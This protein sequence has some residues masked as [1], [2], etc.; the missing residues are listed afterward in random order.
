MEDI[1]PM[2]W[3]T[4]A[5]NAPE[6]LFSRLLRRQNVHEPRGTVHLLIRPWLIMGHRYEPIIPVNFESGPLCHVWDPCL[7]RKLLVQNIL[8][9]PS[10]HISTCLN[11]LA[12]W[13]Q[14]F[15]PSRPGSAFPCT[16]ISHQSNYWSPLTCKYRKNMGVLRQQVCNSDRNCLLLKKRKC[17]QCLLWFH[18]QYGKFQCRTWP[19]R[20]F[21]DPLQVLC[22]L[23]RRLPIFLER[24]S[25]IRWNLSAS[26]NVLVLDQTPNGWVVRWFFCILKAV[27][28]PER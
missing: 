22:P 2:H 11:H 18:I 5:L 28:W 17:K 3:S 23:S 24:T 10:A 20:Y 15:W 26:P 4:Y 19:S 27:V 7:S 14:L 21:C 13:L 25:W 12:L 16:P 6:T 9:G 8:S 1:F